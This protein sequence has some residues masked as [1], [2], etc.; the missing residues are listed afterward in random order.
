MDIENIL[1][2]RY[3]SLK[4]IN[5]G[6]DFFI[7]L[8]EYIQYIYKTPE[9]KEIIKTIEREKEEDYKKY[10]R[11]K[12]KAF[13]EMINSKEEILQIIKK[14]K[15]K[16]ENFVTLRQLRSLEKGTLWMSGLQIEIYN[17]IL[18]EN[19]EELLQKG[20]GKL[21]DKFIVNN[22]GINNIYANENFTF[23]K[24]YKEFFNEKER[25]NSI[26]K[27]KIWYCW[28]QLKFIPEIYNSNKIGFEN[29]ITDIKEE[30]REEDKCYVIEFG[31]VKA[32]QKSGNYAF[33]PD[34]TVGFEKEIKIYKDCAKRLHLYILEELS[35]LKTNTKEEKKIKTVYK[36][37]ILFFK[38]LDFDFNN[39]PLQKDL[40]KTL[41]QD[42][43]RYWSND[44][45]F[46]DWGENDFKKEKTLQFYS[47]GDRINNT[48]AMELKIKDFIIKNIKQ[49]RINPK[50][51]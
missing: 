19:A 10:D 36:D 12:E 25:I 41:F 23:S 5:E 47:A 28:Y 4:D 26:K 39:K 16:E 48:I 35:I 9:I 45:I 3:K 1:E 38:G 30:I 49:V 33:E 42:P 18:Y 50:Y 21:I 8:N 6:W 11:L 51:I 15:I 22:T 27:D 17:T 31:M 20:Y 14:H 7:Y 29:I 24:T 34:T 46:E 32:K 13:R 37:G 2:K 40:L 43:S 44:E